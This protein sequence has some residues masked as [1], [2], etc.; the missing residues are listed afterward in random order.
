MCQTLLLE[1]AAA[2]GD[3]SHR[4]AFGTV[5]AARR[6]EQC[7]KLPGKDDELSCQIGRALYATASWSYRQSFSLPPDTSARVH[8]AHSETQTGGQSMPSYPVDLQLELVRSTRSKQTINVRYTSRSKLPNA[9]EEENIAMR[10]HVD[11][12]IDKKCRGGRSVKGIKVVCYEPRISEAMFPGRTNRQRSPV[13]MHS[14][15]ILLFIVGWYI[16]HNQVVEVLD[17]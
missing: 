16:L 14:S 11:A 8:H 13:E 3:G 5:P 9:T 2:N 12:T 15:T 17:T 7:M 1:V 10:S 4:L 6:I